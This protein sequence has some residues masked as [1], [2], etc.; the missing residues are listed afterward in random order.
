MQSWDKRK[1]GTV[2]K[3]ASSRGEHFVYRRVIFSTVVQFRTVDAYIAQLL[4]FKNL[5]KHNLLC[6]KANNY[7]VRLPINAVFRE[8]SFEFF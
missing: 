7:V 4:I 1:K 2:V 5:S 8:L 6:G 3:K